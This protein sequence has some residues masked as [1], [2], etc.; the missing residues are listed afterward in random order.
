MNAGVGLIAWG[1]YLRAFHR[2]VE[3][4]PKKSQERASFKRCGVACRLSS[5]ESLDENGTRMSPTVGE[6]KYGVTVHA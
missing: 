5:E 4:Q 6:F 3:V 2:D 1:M